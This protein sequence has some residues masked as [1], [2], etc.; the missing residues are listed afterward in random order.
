MNRSLIPRVLLFAAAVAGCGV[1]AE[2]GSIYGRAVQANG[3]NP[4]GPCRA[5]LQPE[6]DRRGAPEPESSA[7]PDSKTSF[8]APLDQQ[9]YFHILGAA[10]G[11]YVLAVECPT[12]SG[13]RELLVEQA[14]DIRIDPP[15]RLE[16]LTFEIAITPKH[17]P[18]GKP[19]QLTIDAT[20]PRL[21]PIAKNVAMSPDGRWRRRGL[22]ADNYRVN[23]SSSDGRPWLQRFFN[24]STARPSLSIRLPFMRVEGE[25]HLASQPV[26]ARLT[27]HNDDG[28]EPMTLISDE[29]GFFQ[30]LLPITPGGVQKTR[31][32]V[33]A[34][35]T[36]APIS[37][38]LSGVSAPS[39]GQ[40]TAWLDLSLPVFAVHGTVTS[41]AE[42]PQAGVQVI[43]EDGSN[44]T[45][46]STATDDT[47]AFE[48]SDL[49]PGKYVAWA[50]SLD[51]VSPRTPFEIIPGA[52]GELHLVLTPSECLPFYVVSRDGPVAGAAV[53][54]WSPPGTPRYFAHTDGEGRF[55]VK[56]PP[57]T[58]EVGL[59]VG[60]PGYALKL[61]RMKISKQSENSREGNTI[62][63]DESGGTLVVDLQPPG[64][65]AEAPATPYLVHDGAIEALG[66]LADWG[67]E[68]PDPGAPGRM[69]LKSI[70]PG[71]Y[72]MCLIRDPAQMTTL[73]MGAL[74]SDQCRKISVEEN[75]TQSVSAY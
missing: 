67:Y 46:T 74:P 72:A 63:L 55:E 9:G 62:E 30:G 43:F 14:K 69:V 15:L 50:E 5:S 28:G 11:K 57:G 53:Q 51:G 48:L 64:P 32:T 34:R 35:G 8:S 4:S 33:E 18:D 2:A 40:T 73:W 17:D 68:Q 42:Q 60:A 70:E 26:R 36:E 38:R 61:T 6:I 58:T 41:E 49:P 21:R 19:W 37:R 13:V 45:R 20:M 3:S 65:S 75:E 10:P 71:D 47:G 54:V 56:L 12:A 39:A 22:V 1:Q 23:I 31:W 44:G 29:G 59:T 7:T 52:E 16:D 25:V 27:F 66:T 24:L